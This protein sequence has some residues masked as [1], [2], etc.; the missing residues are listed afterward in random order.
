MVFSRNSLCGYLLVEGI[1]NG[2]VSAMRFNLFPKWLFVAV[3]SPARGYCDGGR[4]NFEA[5]ANRLK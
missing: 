5:V 2:R 4:F 1:T 3:Q